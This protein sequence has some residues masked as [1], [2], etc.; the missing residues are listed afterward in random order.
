MNKLIKAMFCVTFF[1]ICTRALG[2]LLKIYLSRELG[3]VLLGSYQ[4][5]MSVFGVLVTIVSSGIPVVLS[6][7]VSYLHT[8]NDKKSIGSVVS[9]GLILTIILC[10]FISIITILF[11]QCLNLLF[12]SQASSEM[13]LILVP[14]LIANAIYEVFNGA[15]WGAQEFFAISFNEFLEQLIRIIILVILFNTSAI[16]TT[17]TNKSA[18]SLSLAC[19][20]STTLIIII[21]FKKG[22]KLSNPKPEFKSLLKSSS[23]LTALKT[24][25]SIVSS[26]ISLIIPIRLMTYGYT[27]TEALSEF[28]IVMGM[29]FPLIMIPSTLIGSLAVTITPSI[30]KFSNNINTLNTNDKSFIRNKINSTIKTTAIFSTLLLSTFISLGNPL[31][32]FIYDNTKA[33]VY[34]SA[35]AIAMIPLGISQITS[36]ILNALGLEMKSLKSYAI[37]ALVLIL[38]IFFLPRYIGTYALIVGYF[39]MSVTSASL[40][41][42]LL[43]KHQLVD[44]T[45]FKTIFIMIV[46][47]LFSALLTSSIYNLISGLGILALIISGII[48]ILSTG[49]LLVTFDVAKIKTFVFRKKHRLQNV[50]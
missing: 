27:S 11:P 43:N 25:S 33:G 50:F 6:R 48:S 7:K 31:C 3:S 40:N 5:A 17:L 42:E 24:I 35:A 19:I 47:G 9:S 20:V 18:L 13:M 16:N 41:L 30:S 44:F 39:L 49:V 38:C 1:S 36:A 28:G 37:S 10:L 23:P 46:I 12:I 14:A 22:G 8:Q 45:F 2:F 21:Y 32:T 34:L 29:T 26:F 4:V 15:L